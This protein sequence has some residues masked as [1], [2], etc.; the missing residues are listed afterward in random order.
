MKLNDPR[1]RSILDGHPIADSV[2]GYYG[3]RVTQK[4]SI[5]SFHIT[6]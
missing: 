5:D 3:Q 6:W 1:S 4:E 2:L